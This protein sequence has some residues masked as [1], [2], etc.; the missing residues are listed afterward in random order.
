MNDGDRAAAGDFFWPLAFFVSQCNQLFYFEALAMKM[1]GGYTGRG[2]RHSTKSQRV[3][4]DVLRASREA[5]RMSRGTTED[6]RSTL[7]ITAEEI[8]E[9]VRNSIES[10]WACSGQ[11]ISMFLIQFSRVQEEKTN[12]GDSDSDSDDDDADAALAMRL[13]ER[14]A[15]K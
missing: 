8:I 2:S 12:D 6:F 4:E 9:T 13:A 11:L 14:M 1:A 15:K 10:D 3:S 7:T 5:C